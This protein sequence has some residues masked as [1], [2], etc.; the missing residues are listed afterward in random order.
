MPVLTPSLLF[1][2]LTPILKVDVFLIKTYTQK[3]RLGHLSQHKNLQ[4]P[5]GLITT[6]YL[7]HTLQC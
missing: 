5:S 2:P 6:A 7:L 3:S 4:I 1:L